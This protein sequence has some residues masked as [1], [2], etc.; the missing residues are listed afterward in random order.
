MNHAKTLVGLVLAGLLATGCSMGTKSASLEDYNMALSDAKTAIA[1]ASKVNYV[2]RDTGKL[3]KQAE[4]AAKA[5]DYNKATSLANKAKR[6][7][8]LAFMQYQQQKD[9]GP[10]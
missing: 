5:G 6:Q 7:G 1:K 4:Q 3:L 2:W 8:E 9:A 10:N